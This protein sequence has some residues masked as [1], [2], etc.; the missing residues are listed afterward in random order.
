ME[1]K[2]HLLSLL[3]RNDRMGMSNSI[4]IRCPFLDHQLVNFVIKSLNTNDNFTKK[5]FL[6]KILEK[7]YQ[8]II[9]IFLTK[10]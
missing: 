1:L 7:N 4:E 2:T 3:R 8:I 10:K 9:L 6:E 5:E